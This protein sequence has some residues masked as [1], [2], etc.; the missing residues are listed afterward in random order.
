[1]RCCNKLMNINNIITLDDV[2]VYSQ[3]KLFVRKCAVCSKLKYQLSEF[4][5]ITGE[6][7]FDRN[8]PK[9]INDINRWIDDLINLRFCSADVKKGNKSAMAFIFGSNKVFDNKI[10]QI[11]YDFNGTERNRKVLNDEKKA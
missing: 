8:R 2:D 5:N 1:M 10:V 9:R 7:V 6:F 11:G 4:N 3:R